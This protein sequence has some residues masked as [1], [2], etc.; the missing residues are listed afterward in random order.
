MKIKTFLKITSGMGALMIALG[1]TAA[2]A[3]SP[4]AD[5]VPNAL[6][7]A[8][9]DTSIAT[10]QAADDTDIIVYGIRQSLSKAADKKKNAKQIVDSIV[11]ED[12]GK[13]PDNNVP[14]ALSRVTGVQIDRER[15]QGQ[16]V[17]IRG[18][19]GVQTTINGNS[20][21]LGEARSINLADIPAELLKSVD[22]YKTRTADQVEGSI[23]GTV[24]VEL[25]RPLDLKKGL[26]VAGS[27]RG[28]YDDI[29]EKV[30]P[31]ASLLVGGRW[32]TGIGEIGVLFNGSYTRTNYFENY[33]ESE[34]PDVACCR[35]SNTGVIDP[36]SPLASVPVALRGTIIPYRAFY[37]LER[38][39]VK[40]PSLNAV[41]QWRANDRLDF[42][43]EGGY[44]G[45]REQRQIDRLFIQAREYG[46][47]LS[48]IVVGQ[49]GRTAQQVTI[50]NP[51]GVPAGVDSIYNTFRSN[52]YTTNFEAHWR[53]DRAQINASAQYNWSNDGYYFVEQILRFRNQ[54]SATVNF[55]SDQVPGG[56]PS[57]S[58]G[59]TD[60]SNIANYGVDRFQDNKGQSTNK[61]FAGQVDLTLQL[62][63]ASLLRSLQTGFRYSTRN[64]DR[65]YGYR[66]GLP[67]V[68]GALAPLSAFPGGGQ[69]SLVSPQI[70]GVTSPQWFQIPGAVLL[71][72]IEAIRTYIQQTDP[73]NAA[74]FASEFPSQ[75]RG[76]TFKT[77][78]NTFAAYAQINYAFKLGFPIDGVAG[79]RYTNTYGSVNSFDYRPGDASNG[80]QDIVQAA[81]GRGNYT[82]ILPSINAIVHFTPKVQ[83]RLAYTQNV[84]RPGF[85]DLRPFAFVETRAT[86][87]IV[88]AGNPDL[89]AQRG[90]NWDASLEYYFGRAGSITLA[91]YIKTASGYL[92]YSREEEADLSR[93]G[94]PGQSGFVEQQ[95]NAGKGTFKG[96]EASAQSFFDFLPGFWRNFGAS[97]NFT[98]LAKAR[99]EYPYP[100]D[101][102]GAF[103][104]PG[105]SKYTVNA[106]L[107]YDTPTF[108]TRIAYNYR[109]SYRLGIFVD[110]PEYS[111][112]NGNTSR[113]D[114]AVN[115]TP[116]KFMTLSLEG[117]N[118][119]GDDNRR[120][121][122]QQNL[123]PLG[124]R[125]QARTLQASARFR[126]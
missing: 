37:G 86:P 67:R 111:P 49:D 24:N 94:L 97:A 12:V 16:N 11:S 113:L 77:N 40:R 117:T 123:L 62:S 72:N 6:A 38:G 43:L 46:S 32:D 5:P 93:F 1:A 22:V 53:G 42:V 47:T 19:G 54:T 66:D 114:A 39:N 36:N 64:S 75:D 124:V 104:F 90:T 71:D 120:Y 125:F 87:P 74:R 52:L 85:Y 106:A 76:Q 28:V 59:N 3:E 18:Q 26:T 8:V 60:L 20:T 30:S 17:T 116:V 91:G 118:L 9:Q 105:T 122:G 112:Y 95:R 102:P 34:S 82:D 69:A 44:I 14:E 98:Y 15:G 89:K 29:S 126:F 79:V 108:S 21:S 23:S 103:D 45:A 80:F 4:G 57:I 51:N 78:E 56:A 119:L 33:I 84:Q 96:I 68:A 7:P 41:V 13:L 27:V 81:T 2:S 100:E 63:D 48:N 35:D 99:V 70:D 121:F 110:N 107:Y 50:N 25:R 83:L 10:D 61:E 115:F 65:S 88:F 92:Y 55:N 31:Y 109:S 58:F 101:F 73:G